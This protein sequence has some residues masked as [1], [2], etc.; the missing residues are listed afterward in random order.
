MP[1]F[2]QMGMLPKIVCIEYEMESCIIINLAVIG[3][4]L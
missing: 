4:G 1:V 2:A 3:T